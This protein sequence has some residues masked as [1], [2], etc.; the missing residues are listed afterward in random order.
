[1][2]QYSPA[3]RSEF[4]AS[5]SISLDFSSKPFSTSSRAPIGSIARIGGMNGSH[6]RIMARNRS[7]HVSSRI[8]PNSWYQPPRNRLTVLVSASK[9]WPVWNGS[10]GLRS[11]FSA[12]VAL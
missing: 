8:V 4:S 9:P 1:L 11:S 2:S 10:H 7:S 12:N 6:A 5:H 3:G